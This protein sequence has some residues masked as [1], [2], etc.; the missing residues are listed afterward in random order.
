MSSE[1][2]EVIG[3][4]VEK[5]VI[6]QKSNVVIELG[7]LLIQEKY[8][9]TLLL[10]QVYELSYGSQIS[11]Q[12]REMISG[13]RLE[14]L[15]KGL[16]FVEPQ[17]RNYIIAYAKP[18]LHIGNVLQNPKTL[19]N[20]FGPVR[21]VREEDLQF[22]TRPEKSIFFGNVRSG[23][24]T[25]TTQL[26]L[27]GSETLSHHVLTAATTGRGKSNLVKVILWHILDKDFVGFLILD[28]HNEY[29]GITNT[30]GLRDHPKSRQYLRYY[31]NGKSPGSLPLLINL[32]SLT[33]G[34]FRGIIE[35]SDA[36]QEA[37]DAAYNIFREDWI[38]NIVRTEPDTDEEDHRSP[39]LRAGVRA[40]TIAVLRRKFEWVLGVYYDEEDDQIKFRTPVFG[41]SGGESTI[42]EILNDL[43]NGKK[44]I[45]DT[46]ML[47][48]QSELLIGSMITNEV[49]NNYKRLK[50]LDQ[51][52]DK[53]VISIVVEEAPRILSDEVLKMTGSNIYS[54]IAREGR[55]FKVGLTAITQLTSVIP[56]TI[57][58]NLNTKIILGNELSSER[59]AL[60][61]SASQDLSG[62]D[63]NIRRLDKG[64]AIVSS[65]FAKFAVPIKIPL[66]QE[67]IEKTDKRPTPNKKVRVIT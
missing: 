32:R 18:I 67:L 26:Y 55:K 7:D 57:L 46:S 29:Y 30:K 47:K 65:N 42:K 19:P 60:I 63:Q 33:P 5:L 54:D 58:A 61:Q 28:P 16:D 40:T 39:I 25:L 45:I 56:K 24:K 6:R 53:P 35:L 3:G 9:N 43:Q 13:I 66:F 23:S 1:C 49:L 52:A 12:S 17:L 36:Q 21:H 15:G 62:D 44:V 31:S 51:L 37:M 14:G 34:H 2:G 10:M 22:L 4:E 59:L 41:M 38:Q 8:D 48:D 20:L 27:D 64:E 50:E 11:Q